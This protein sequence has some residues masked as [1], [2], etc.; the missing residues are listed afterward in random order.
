M[1]GKSTRIILCLLI[2]LCLPDAVLA[3]EPPNEPLL[4]LETGMY[5]ASITRIGV[6]KANRLLVTASIDKMVRLWEPTTGRL[7]RIIRRPAGV[8]GTRRMYGG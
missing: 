6:D 5:T 1:N 2:I 7:V 4:S 3:A 8:S